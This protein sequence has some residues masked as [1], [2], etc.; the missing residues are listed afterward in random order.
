MQQT[1][2]KIASNFLCTATAK[3]D[4]RRIMSGTFVLSDT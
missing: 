3:Y 2:E 4:T 1:L